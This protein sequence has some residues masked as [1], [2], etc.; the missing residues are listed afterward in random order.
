MAMEMVRGEVLAVRM[1]RVL[2][3][4]LALVPVRNPRVVG[5]TKI[6]RTETGVLS[7]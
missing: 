3:P 5:W 2:L 4:S 7:E 6:V 1:M